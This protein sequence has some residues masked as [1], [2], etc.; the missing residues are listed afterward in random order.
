[1][2]VRNTSGGL[3]LPDYVPVPDAALGPQLNEQGYHVG[4]VEQ[5]LFWVTDGTY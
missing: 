5:N 1:M 2:A 3:P 4:R